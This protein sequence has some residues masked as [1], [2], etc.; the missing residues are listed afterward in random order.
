[1]ISQ[2]KVYMNQLTENPT[3]SS[4]ELVEFINSSRIPGAA[5]L[6]H[7]DFLKKVVAVLGETVAGNFTGY[8]KASN[9]KQNPC[10]NFPKREACLMA[11]SYSYD[12]QAKV[13]DRMTALES[14]VT[15]VTQLSPGEM[16]L[17]QCQLIVDQE[18]R[19][20]IVEAQATEQAAQM[21]ATEDK[22]KRIEAKQQAFEEGSKY[23]TVIGFFVYR[24]LPSLTLSDAA[25]F[26]KR[27]AQLSKEAGMLVDK[28]RDPRFGIVNSYHEDILQAVLT[29]YMED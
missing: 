22:V 17:A 9:G 13:Y 6:A 23:F 25:K 20:A 19:L 4:L 27:A 24:G 1:M 7:A 14:K 29:E 16:M 11:M 12:L 10:Y 18:R 2:L 3:M 28:V 8:Y 21:A 26:G 15:V 5:T